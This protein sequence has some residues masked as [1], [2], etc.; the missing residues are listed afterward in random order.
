MAENFIRMLS[1][2]QNSYHV[3]LFACCRE[4]QKSK[5]EFLSLEQAKLQF[6]ADLAEEAEQKKIR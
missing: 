3:S 5:Y 2:N 1:R 6:K 4:K